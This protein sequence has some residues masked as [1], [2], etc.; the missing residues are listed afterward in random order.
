MEERRQGGRGGFI[1]G[2]RPRGG[3]WKSRDGTLR[4]GEVPCRLVV[5]FTTECRAECV[6]I[7]V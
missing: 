4:V 1:R 6:C 7:W 3:C 5:E 2:R